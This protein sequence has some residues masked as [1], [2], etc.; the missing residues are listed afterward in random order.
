M[1]NGKGGG[2][3]RLVVHLFGDAAGDSAVGMIRRIAGSN[4][5]FAALVGAE[6]LE[7][8]MG[9]EAAPAALRRKFGACGARETGRPVVGGGRFHGS[10]AWTVKALC[11]ALGKRQGCPK[12]EESEKQ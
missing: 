6:G 10:R 8:E 11:L 2:S 5:V 12:I 4:S 9:L 7:P 1:G 3:R